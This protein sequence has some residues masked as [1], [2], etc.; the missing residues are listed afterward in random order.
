MVAS[1]P[2][3]SAPSR[4]TSFGG[5]RPRPRSRPRLSMPSTSTSSSRVTS[6]STSVS[7]FPFPSTSSPISSPRQLLTPRKLDQH[8]YDPFRELFPLPS[9]PL[10]YETTP[11]ADVE[12]CCALRRGP[13]RCYVVAALFSRGELACAL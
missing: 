13:A 12:H 1:R 6:T 2:R 5:S 7:R 9:H 4:S 8:R 11:C 3:Q 10:L